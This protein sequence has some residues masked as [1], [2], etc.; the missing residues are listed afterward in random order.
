MDRWC[1]TT[2]SNAKAKANYDQSL[3]L[4]NVLPERK[5]A[6][7]IDH[8][9]I[10]RHDTLIVNLGQDTFPS[11]NLSIMAQS[12]GGGSP[13]NCGYMFFP[14]RPTK[15]LYCCIGYTLAIVHCHDLHHVLAKCVDEKIEVELHILFTP[16]KVRCSK[17]NIL[18]L[19]TFQNWELL[20][21]NLQK[22]NYTFMKH[23]S[24]ATLKINQ[25]LWG[26]NE[27][28][29]HYHEKNVT[30]ATWTCMWWAR[31]LSPRKVNVVNQLA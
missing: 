19:K 9:P 21:K 18:S 22:S 26:N 29:I 4:W 14:R 1:N 28:N 6:D 16:R 7:T 2:S 8:W 15:S 30:N 20:T 5:N 27:L 25:F 13:T 23:I 24:A 31:R 10:S 12:W 11:V 17:Y 3:M